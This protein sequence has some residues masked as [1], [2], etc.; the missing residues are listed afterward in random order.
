MASVTND[1]PN[2]IHEFRNVKFAVMPNQN[3]SCR[4]CQC[5]SVKSK[6]PLVVFNGPLPSCRSCHSERHR[7]A[8]KRSMCRFQC[9]MAKSRDSIVAFNGPLPSRRNCNEQY[10]TVEAGHVFKRVPAAPTMGHRRS[11][12]ILQVVAI[13]IPNVPPWKL[14]C[15]LCVASRF[16]AQFLLREPV[17]LRSA[18]SA[19][20]G[21]WAGGGMCCICG[22]KPL[23][24]IF[25]TISFYFWIWCCHKKPLDR[26]ILGTSFH[27]F[28]F[29]VAPVR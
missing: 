25:M 13:A 2:F 22:G 11:R 9:A 14:E 24:T 4:K 5:A 7:K 1:L 12:L 3:G 16:Y 15:F 29:S 6:D 10:T 26:E 19:L 20:C 23:T 27:G 28:L 21:R 18:A 8:I 17:Y